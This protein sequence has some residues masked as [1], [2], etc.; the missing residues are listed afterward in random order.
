MYWEKNICHVSEIHVLTSYFNCLLYFKLTHSIII[1][2]RVLYMWYKIGSP[3]ENEREKTVAQ[4]VVVMY[5]CGINTSINSTPFN[6]TKCIY[7][8]TT[9]TCTKF[10]VHVSR[11]SSQSNGLDFGFMAHQQYIGHF[12]PPGDVRMIQCDSGVSPGSLTCTVPVDTHY[13][14]LQLVSLLLTLCTT[15]VTYKT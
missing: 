4:R 14:I 13:S 7:I 6:L 10:N 12:E 8:F 2:S 1:C 5:Y 9:D 11:F 3:C 15:H